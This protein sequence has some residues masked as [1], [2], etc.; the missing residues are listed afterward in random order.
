MVKMR[1]GAIILCGAALA[2][3]VTAEDADRL[4]ARGETLAK[5]GRYSDAIDAFKAADRVERRAS[6][7]CLIALAYTRRELWPQAEIFMAKCHERARPD[8]PA[9]DWMTKAEQQIS[10]RLATANVAPISITTEPA[11]SAELTVSSFAPDESFSRRTIH[12]PFGQ[13]VIFAKAQGYEVAKQEIDVRDR[14]PQSVVIHLVKAGEQ[15]ASAIAPP[16]PPQPSRTQLPTKP[17]LF[18]G[19]GLI[20]AGVVVNATFYLSARDQLAESTTPAEY[21]RRESAYDISRTVMFGLYGVG[22]AA[23]ITGIVF[24][25]LDRDREPTIATV[26]IRGGGIIALEWRR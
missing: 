3:E 25:A 12:L 15:P 7:A 20:A 6:H 21:Q 4:R 13:H 26:P 11:V 1:I 22:A 10:E 19:A 18:A 24:F 14:K 8:D 16:P 9:P 2:S 23:A 17:V 5:D